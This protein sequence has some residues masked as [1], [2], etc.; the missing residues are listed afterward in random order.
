MAKPI[1]ILKLFGGCEGGKIVYK[2]VK[3]W[4]E[5][6]NKDAPSLKLEPKLIEV[7]K[8]YAQ[9][10]DLDRVRLTSNAELPPDWFAPNYA[11]ITFGYKIYF[12]HTFDSSDKDHIKFIV[13]EIYHVDQFRRYGSFNNFACAYGKGYVDADFS[14]EN[15]QLEKDANGFEDRYWEEIYKKVNE[16]SEKPP[17]SQMRYRRVQKDDA[18]AWLVM[19]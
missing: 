8:E 2:L 10:I 7:L 19:G 3:K 4:T 18:A 15:N 17:I 5:E 14:Y 13:H 16:K 9:L 6:L 1:D 11:G 12:R